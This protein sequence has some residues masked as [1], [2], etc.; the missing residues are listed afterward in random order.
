MFV[1][2]F[3]GFVVLFLI[4]HLCVLYVFRI[5]SEYLSIQY[6]HNS[7]QNLVE[8]C[9]PRSTKCNRTS[10]LKTTKMQLL[11]GASSGNGG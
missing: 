10:T 7:F 11:S 5:N 9:L 1:Y 3:V 4:M 6:Y 8:V 2:A